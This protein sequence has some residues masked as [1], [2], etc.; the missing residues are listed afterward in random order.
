MYDR[1]LLT[2]G[3]VQHGEKSAQ[4]RPDGLQD[5]NSPPCPSQK[6]AGG[7]R[8]WE[9]ADIA[10]TQVAPSCVAVRGQEPPLGAISVVAQWLVKV[11]AGAGGFEPPHGGIKIHCLTAWR[12]PNARLAPDSPCRRA[13]H[14]AGLAEPQLPERVFPCERKRSGGSAGRK[15][16]N[17]HLFRPRGP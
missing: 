14:K 11:L 3:H 12:R 17:P 10:D 6:R 15:G 4:D 1:H 13:D 2:H 5:A 9:T 8:T 7:R 16:F